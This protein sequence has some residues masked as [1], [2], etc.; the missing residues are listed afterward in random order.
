[1]PA[2]FDPAEYGRYAADVYDEVY[3]DLS[4]D[5]AVACVADLAGDGTVLELGIGTGRLAMPLVARGIPVDGIDGSP[6]MVAGLRRKPGGTDLRVEIGDFATTSMGR[7]YRVV[8][9]AFNTINALPSQDA[10]V[11]T[12]RN[13][14]DHLEPGGVFLLENWV[15][16]PAAFTRGRAVRVH[17][18]A[19][20]RVVIDVALLHQAEQRMT[21][22]KLA[23]TA[24]GVR[25]L[26]ANHRYVWPA[27]LDLMARLAGLSLEDRWAD[28][29]RRPFTDESPAYVVAYRAPA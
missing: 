3:A 7:R 8:L 24:D 28:W 1:M 18:V 14:A 10:Q 11:E 9:L 4:P 15:P 12:F 16:D 29:E 17:E 19:G 6:D 25:L 21:T 20:D 23:F 5:A 2:P 13:A 26:P 22:T 27:E